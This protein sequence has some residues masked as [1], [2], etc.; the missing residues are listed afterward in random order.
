MYYRHFMPQ[1]SLP[2]TLPRFHRFRQMRCM[3]HSAPFTAM[4]QIHLMQPLMLGVAK[5]TVEIAIENKFV[6]RNHGATL[7]KWLAGVYSDIHIR[8]TRDAQQ[9]RRSALNNGVWR[10]VGSTVDITGSMRPY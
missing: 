2:R 7:Q 4:Q 9:D 10:L 5:R 1:F 6:G 8:Q 3:L